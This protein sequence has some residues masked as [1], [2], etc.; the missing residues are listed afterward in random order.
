MIFWIAS[1]PKSG[2]T[3]LRALIS[4][5]YYTNDGEFRE[6]IIKKIGQFPEKRFFTEF[7]YDP[8]IVTDTTRF[9]IKAQQKINEDN[10]L[11]FFKTHNVFGKLNNYD[12]TDSKNSVGCIYVIRDPRNVITSIKNHYELNDDQALKWMMN[13]KNYIYDV[14]NL[15]KDGYS[16]FQFISSWSTNYKSWKLQKKIPLKIIKYEDLLSKTYS[17]FKDVIQFINKITE[18]E[19]KIDNTKIKNAV[20][21]TLFDKLK[22]YEIKNGFSEAIQSKKKNEKIPF[23]FL[24][25]K[26]DWKKILDQNLQIKISSAFKDDFSEL[27]Y[28]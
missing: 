27:G 26:N 11:R 19:N 14:S 7:K 4:S 9:W 22:N 5:Y 12:F 28:D 16:D 8:K 2:N 20:N 13:E 23:F 6:N 10:Q 18:K 21:S 24:G 25:P 15:E 17:V 1:Y 3:W